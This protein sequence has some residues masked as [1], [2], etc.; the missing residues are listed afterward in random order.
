M[1]FTGGRK[2][3]VVGSCGRG[4]WRVFLAL[5]MVVSIGSIR[6][7]S[8]GNWVSVGSVRG[9]VGDGVGVGGV[10]C[11]GD[12]VEN[13]RLVVVVWHDDDDDDAFRRCC[14]CCFLA[15]VAVFDGFDADADLAWAERC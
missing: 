5:A 4:V 3:G 11:G 12:A 14:C 10:G 6:A 13:W 9:V 8:G 1:R 2:S 15:V 7:R